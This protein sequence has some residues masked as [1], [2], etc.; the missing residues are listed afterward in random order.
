M[1][2]FRN[3]AMVWLKPHGLAAGM[4]CSMDYLH[5]CSIVVSHNGENPTYP[6][7]TLC[8]SWFDGTKVRIASIGAPNSTIAIVSMADVFVDRGRNSSIIRG[9]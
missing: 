1:M 7:H 8:S 6:N 2:Y 5:G 4:R 3:W 9:T